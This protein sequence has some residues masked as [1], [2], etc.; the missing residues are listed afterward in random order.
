MPDKV[1]LAELLLRITVL[2]ERAEQARRLA[3]QISD[4]QAIEGLYRGAEEL[5]RRMKELEA[6]VAVSMQAP[7]VENDQGIAAFRLRADPAKK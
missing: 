3:A 2:R 6:Q 5:D 7:Q 1:E 4:K